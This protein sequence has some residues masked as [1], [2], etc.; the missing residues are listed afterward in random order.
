MVSRSFFLE[1]V[2]WGIPL[3]VF[4]GL[5]SETSAS[6]C[7]EHLRVVSKLWGL[8]KGEQAMSL[9][10]AWGMELELWKPR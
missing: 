2:L 1:T 3:K 6:A 9:P 10:G 7:L 4:H 5:C 8:R